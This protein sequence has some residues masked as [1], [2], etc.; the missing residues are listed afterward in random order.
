MGKRKQDA[1]RLR[2]Y[3]LVGQHTDMLLHQ[4]VHAATRS[5]QDASRQKMT[6]TTAMVATGGGPE[7]ELSKRRLRN[8][9]MKKAC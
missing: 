9:T 7:P 5:V 1:L 3:Q 8:Y 2:V 6:L 4:C